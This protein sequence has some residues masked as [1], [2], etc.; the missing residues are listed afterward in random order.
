MRAR[1]DFN[2]IAPYYDTLKRMVFGKTI[3]QS[4]LCFLGRIRC[5][6]K[7]LIIGGGSG[8]I[9]IPIIEKFPACNIWY[10]EASSR[11]IELAK[12]RLEGREA[13]VNFIEGSLDS[14]SPHIRFD[15]VITNFFLDMFPD[16]K[17]K[18]IGS[19]VANWL[20]QDGVWI[21][22]DFVDSRKWRYQILLKIMYIFFRISCGIE[23]GKLPSWE[24]EVGR[25][26][27]DARASQT[28][29][30]GFIKASLWVKPRPRQFSP[31][32]L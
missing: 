13:K 5:G 7:V 12:R 15:A 1:N 18:R 6:G 14:L 29:F 25:N 8:E 20:C 32:A 21:V 4:Q 27:F 26:G 17:V 16:E 10:I 11:M 22:T 28:F 24:T 19:M 23:A 3:A 9:L 30:G 31:E 2:A